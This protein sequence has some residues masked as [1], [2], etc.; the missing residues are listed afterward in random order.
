MSLGVCEQQ[1]RRPDCASAQSD[2]RL[3]C[4][5]I[6]K[7]HLKNCY[8]EIFLLPLHFAWTL[9][10]ATSYSNSFLGTLQMLMHDKMWDPYI[11][12]CVYCTE[13]LIQCFVKE[14]ESLRVNLSFFKF[15]S[16]KDK[17]SK[18][19]INRFIAQVTLQ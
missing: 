10:L 11:Q 4:W 19:V 9:G 5:L 15:C 13:S 6:G 17:I 16:I 2:Q 18:S 8:K 1:R 14:N 12:M 7:Y 3:C